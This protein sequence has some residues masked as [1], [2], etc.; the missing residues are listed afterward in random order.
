MHWQRQDNY[1]NELESGYQA[2][3]LIVAVYLTILLSMSG[4]S[5]AS[6]VLV[7]HFHHHADIQAIPKL[8]S[9]VHNSRVYNVQRSKGINNNRCRKNSGI[10]KE[11]N[12]PSS[13][14]LLQDYMEVED[15]ADQSDSEAHDCC[16]K[17]RYKVENWRR[18]RKRRTLGR[19]F[20]EKL[21]R[22]LFC[23]VTV[24]TVLSTIIVMVLLIYW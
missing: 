8:I 2:N 21:D 10:K 23:T 18:R 15:S 7:L 13:E 6:T 5:V 3:F 14:Q 1:K 20:A 12:R 24:L 19:E 4:L 17:L 9:E 16:R 22:G 11:N